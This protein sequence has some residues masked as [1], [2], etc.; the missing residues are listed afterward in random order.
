MLM[1][2]LVAAVILPIVATPVCNLGAWRATP[3][4]CWHGA[5]SALADRIS[6][7]MAAS[8]GYPVTIVRVGR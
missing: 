2:A 6:G 4:A 3:G 1:I 8:R 5:W 7:N